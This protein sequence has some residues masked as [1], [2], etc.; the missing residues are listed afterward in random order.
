MCTN[1]SRAS[2]ILDIFASAVNFVIYLILGLF[3]AEQYFTMKKLHEDEPIRSYVSESDNV[4]TNSRTNSNNSPYFLKVRKVINI[5]FW[6]LT[7]CAFLLVT[8]FAILIIVM[9]HSEFGYS[10]WAYQLSRLAIRLIMSWGICLTLL[11]FG[12][13]VFRLY[14]RHSNASVQST[15]NVQKVAYITVI[16]T[17]A[18][19][20][21]SITNVVSTIKWEWY[22]RFEH[23]KFS[24]IDLQL[25]IQLAYIFYIVGLFHYNC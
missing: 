9:D 8:P 6:I 24:N 21:L 10:T 25:I 22:Q 19:F 13:L 1:I 23:G 11:V 3:W 12:I 20:F 18:Y 15:R 16:C 14:R 5:F 4:S 17:C 7:L 2:Q